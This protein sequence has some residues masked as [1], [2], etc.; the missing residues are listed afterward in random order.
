MQLILDANW[1][2]SSLKELGIRKKTYFSL[3]NDDSELKLL[4]SGAFVF[5]S[6]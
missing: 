6:A 2:W 4:S 3:F 5:R 1:V